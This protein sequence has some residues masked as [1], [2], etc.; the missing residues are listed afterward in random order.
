[1][2]QGF[3]ARGNRIAFNLFH[4]IIPLLSG[5]GFEF[6]L[7]QIFDFNDIA[8]LRL[9]V[10]QVR[11][12]EEVAVAVVELNLRCGDVVVVQIQLRKEETLDVALSLD[13]VAHR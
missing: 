3:H 1:M 4:G 8:V 11:Q 12:E 10:G 2:A 6:A 13:A 5:L 7:R 9:V